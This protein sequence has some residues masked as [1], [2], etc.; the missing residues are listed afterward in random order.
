ME[1]DRYPH[2][3]PCWIDLRT[4]DVEASVAFYTRLLG[5]SPDER[6]SFGSSPAVVGRLRDA[7][8]A[9]IG[10]RPEPA[11]TTARWDMYVSVT[12]ADDTIERVQDAGGQ[13]VEKP[14]D[15]AGI[16]RAAVV[17]DATGAELGVLEATQTGGVGAVDEPGTWVFN[18]LN[19]RHP[20][21]AERFYGA[22]FGWEASA[23]DL[24]DGNTTTMWRR[25]GYG[26]HLDELN[27]GTQ[28]GH[29]A[30]GAP[31]GFSDAVGWMVLLDDDAVDPT[32]H[33]SVMFAVEDADATVARAVELG[34]EVVTPP[35]DANF[36][37]MAVL[38][39]PQGA[40]LT[41]SRFQ[42]PS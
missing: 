23:V 30:M 1:R 36:V 32:E 26:D 38:R 22:V 33:W 2:G 35:F 34:A 40:V 41:V 42:P 18:D 8:V 27:P 16:G 20:A 24:G 3:V 15:V 31:E 5:W 29:R 7:D 17:A 37:R 11:P 21:E 9:S 12:S 6:S 14:A 25:P 13:I 10:L 39:D 28:E 4:P 19:T